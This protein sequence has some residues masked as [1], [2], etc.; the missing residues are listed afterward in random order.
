MP[1]GF[2]ERCDAKDRDLKTVGNFIRVCDGVV[3]VLQKKG[4]SDT[5]KQSRKEGQ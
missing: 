1:V 2:L 5:T 3:K 4:Q